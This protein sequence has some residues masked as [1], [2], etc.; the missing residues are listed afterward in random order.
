M[1]GEHGP[2]WDP[3][4]QPSPGKATKSIDAGVSDS[5]AGDEDGTGAPLVVAVRED[6]PPEAE[7]EAKR[8]DP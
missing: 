7:Q 8:K 6:G 5:T 3:L 2:L 4:A 1:W